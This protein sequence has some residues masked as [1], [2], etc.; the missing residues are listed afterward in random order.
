MIRADDHSLYTGVT[1]DVERRLAEHKAEAS[2]P[3]RGAKAL[4][5]KQNLKLVYSFA[6]ADQSQALKLEYAIKRLSKAC[7]EALVAGQLPIGE[8]LA[9]DVRHGEH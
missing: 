4:K 8:L 2:G 1:T 3:Y 7:K 9:G 6:A 5:G